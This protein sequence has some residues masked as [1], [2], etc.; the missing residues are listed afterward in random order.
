[1]GPALR[2]YR[3]KPVTPHYFSYQ[4]DRVWGYLYF[5]NP[6]PAR[7]DSDSKVIATTN[8]G[9]CCSPRIQIPALVLL[10]VGLAFGA[11]ST[12]A[13]LFIKSVGVDLNVG[14][15]YSCCDS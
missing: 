1:M 14:L 10:L 7:L 12:F 11:L 5:P 13:P 3:L 9:D 4:L 8:F 6:Q 2:F 15:F